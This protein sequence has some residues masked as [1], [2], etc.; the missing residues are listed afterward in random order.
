[1]VGPEG[2]RHLTSKNCMLIAGILMMK[3]FTN[4]VRAACASNV[5]N[6]FQLDCMTYEH[7][8]PLTFDFNLTH[9]AEALV[10]IP[11]LYS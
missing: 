3:A 8:N 2:A 11:P 10:P 6:R 5:R 9:S 7:R 4:H 1:M